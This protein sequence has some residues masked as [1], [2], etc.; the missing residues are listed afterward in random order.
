MDQEGTGEDVGL[1]DEATD[2]IQEDLSLEDEDD[3]MDYLEKPNGAV[4]DTDEY[5]K[6]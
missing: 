1:E 2:E 5:P 4:D 3:E 6:S